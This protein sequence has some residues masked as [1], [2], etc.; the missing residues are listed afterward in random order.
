MQPAL[1]QLPDEPTIDG[2]ERQLASLGLGPVAGHVVED[3]VDLGAGKI[4]I[5]DQPGAI[6]N[7]GFMTLG[8]QLVAQRRGPAILPN[9][10]VAYRLPGF[11]IP[12]DGRFALIGDAKRRDILDRDPGPAERLDGDANLGRPNFE[13]IVLD[14]SGFRIDLVEFFLGNG[15]DGAITIEND[16]PSA[17]GA[18][19]ESEDKGH[20]VS[21]EGRR[22][23]QGQD[24]GIAIGISRGPSFACWQARAFFGYNGRAGR[25]GGQP[26][27]FMTGREWMQGTFHAF[28]TGW[29]THLSEA[30]NEG[31]LPHGYYAMPEQHAGR[32]TIA[33]VLTL[34]V[35]DAGPIQPTDL[36][37]IAVA[38]APPQVS[39]KMVVRPPTSYR[40]AQRTLTVRRRRN[41]RIVAMVEIVSP[42]NK[43]RARS[44]NEFADKVY[45]ALEHG[46]HLLLIDLLP[47]GPHDPQGM[48]YAIWENFDNEHEEPPPPADKPLSLASYLA[49]PFPEASYEPIA[50][51][52]VL[53]PMPLFLDPDWYVNTPLEET[54][55][56]AFRGMPAFWCE[57]LD[58]TTRG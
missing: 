15:P 45:D 26:C 29:I 44:V 11:A 16:G 14:P 55:Q 17:G 22:C 33:D 6:A 2:A 58:K 56:A 35:G 57:A 41:H 48:H 47:H 40:L 54:Y 23:G 4:R 52:D 25:F 18:L 49:L 24:R 46:C 39:R 7:K 37:P 51:G 43:D 38:E 31:L 32:R 28:H 9:D 34:Q 36:G 3:P 20:G 1:G 21:G 27:R 10:G 5:D 8:P 50:V 13:R 30:L 19:V 42:A 12:N 53:P